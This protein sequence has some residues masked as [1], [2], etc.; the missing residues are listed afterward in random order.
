M[1]YFVIFWLCTFVQIS[2][3][4]GCD[5]LCVFVEI[6]SIFG[7]EH[8]NTIHRYS[9]MGI[10]RIMGFTMF[11]FVLRSGAQPPCRK[12]SIFCHLRGDLSE[13][14]WEGWFSSSF[15]VGDPQISKSSQIYLLFGQCSSDTQLFGFNFI[16]IL[17]DNTGNNHIFA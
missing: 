8:L 9:P 10:K 16:R 4:F 6:S 3:I 13:R 14:Q 11:G 17:K 15:L 7:C 12:F 1:K 5:S 2:S